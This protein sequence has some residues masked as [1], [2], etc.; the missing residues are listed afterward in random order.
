[1]LFEQFDERQIGIGVRLFKHVA[2]IAAR[3]MRVNQQDEM[4][5]LGHGDRFARTHHTVRRKISVSGD[6]EGGPKAQFGTLME[7]AGGT[8][9]K[10]RADEIDTGSRV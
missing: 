10:T 8:T 3:L 9:G 4:E 2:E 1:M 7:R 6:E 5:R